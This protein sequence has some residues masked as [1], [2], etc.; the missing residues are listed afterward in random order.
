MEGSQRVGPWKGTHI[1]KQ[2][3]LFG[4]SFNNNRHPIAGLQVLISACKVICVPISCSGSVNMW[5]SPNIKA[6]IRLNEGLNNTLV[7]LGHVEY[8]RSDWPVK[9]KATDCLTYIS[10]LCVSVCVCVCTCGSGSPS[11]KGVSSLMLPRGINVTHS[12]VLRDLWHV[13]M[14]KKRVPTGFVWEKKESDKWFLA[15]K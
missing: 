5:Q 1:W 2:N 3:T 7:K 12:K 13:L 15:D 14:V 8:I 11:G 9:S 6:E 4:Y 10:G